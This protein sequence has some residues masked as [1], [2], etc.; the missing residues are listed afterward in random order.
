M[1][2]RQDA[3]S[4][5]AR[6]DASSLSRRAFLAGTTGGAALALAGCSMGT[7]QLFTGGRSGATRAAPDVPHSHPLGARNPSPLFY[8]VQPELH[9]ASFFLPPKHD[10]APTVHDL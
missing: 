5:A 3:R 8:C 1:T 9:L 10:G 2:R 7:K 4:G 6:S